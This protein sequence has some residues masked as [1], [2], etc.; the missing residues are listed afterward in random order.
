MGILISALLPAVECQFIKSPLNA[1]VPF[2]T[3]VDYG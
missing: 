1:V 2:L 3:T